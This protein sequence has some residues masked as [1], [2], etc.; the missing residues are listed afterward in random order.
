MGSIGTGLGL[1]RPGRIQLLVTDAAGIGLLAAIST[2]VEFHPS[3]FV[4]VEHFHNILLLPN[5]DSLPTAARCTQLTNMACISDTSM[6][7]EGTASRMTKIFLV[8][9]RQVIRAGLGLHGKAIS[10]SWPIHCVTQ[11]Q[12]PALIGGRDPSNFQASLGM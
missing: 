3:L 10:A 7:C 11:T 8:V 1:N 5:L 4:L 9:G 6:S 12:N 2:S